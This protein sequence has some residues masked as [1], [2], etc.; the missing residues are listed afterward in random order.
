MFYG[1]NDTFVARKVIKGSW[2][3][4][5]A[6]RPVTIHGRRVWL[7]KVYRRWINTYVDME[8]WTR[9]EYGTIF[10]VIKDE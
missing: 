5:F 4:W 6:W 7:K 2:Q 8:D 1:P 9:Y 10:D 3:P